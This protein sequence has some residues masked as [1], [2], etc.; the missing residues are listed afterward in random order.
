MLDAY[1]IDII[2]RKGEKKDDRVQP[3]V[4]VDDFE[5]PRAPIEIKKPEKVSE[6]GV[7][8]ITDFFKIQ[9]EGIVRE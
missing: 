1:I 9:L 2:R 7:L 8:D 5:D 4:G 6:R 3:S